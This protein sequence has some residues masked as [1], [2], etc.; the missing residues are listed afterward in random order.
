MAILVGTAS[1]TD[2]T[3]IDCG[4]FYPKGCSTPEARLRHYASVFPMVEVDSSYYA[5][6]AVS[7]SRNWAMRTP[8]EFVFN[9]K[10]FRIF[11][12]HQTSPAV[13]PKDMQA[14][15]GDT[16]KKM[17]YDR[18]LPS[19][20]RDELW[21]RFIEAISPLRETGKLAAVHFQFAPWVLRNRDGHA[22]V[23]E[24]VTRMAGFHVSVEF[25]NATWFAP[26]HLQGTLQFERTLG[27]THTVVDGPQGFSSSIAQVWEATNPHLAILRLH[28][29]NSQTWDAKGL[30]AASDRFD[31][32]YPDQQ[33][34]DLV[35]HIL[36]LAGK[37]GTLQVI[38]NNNQQD[39]G[40]RNALSLMG[41]LKSA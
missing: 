31:F 24:C 4:R 8:P 26:D 7:V 22:R 1:W 10:A 3:L 34:A 23:E 29:R 2:K 17:L 39:Q 6:P 18:D 15:L 12:G 35:P 41:M 40:Q 32:D 21:R 14:A 37:V 13:L 28:G 33:L 11:T 9:I 20:I 5:I 25:R 30:A 19:E 16:G 38:F 36:R 27:V